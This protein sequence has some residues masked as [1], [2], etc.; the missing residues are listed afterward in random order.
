M[1]PSPALR[2]S[3][4]REVRM[5]NHHKRGRSL[6]GGLLFKDKDDDLALF[7]DMQNRERDNFLLQ[8]ADDLDDSLSTKLRYFSDFKLGISIPARG[9]SSDL[10]N[11]DGDKNDYDWL[12][13][14]PGTP[15]FPSLDDDP[16]PS[17]LVHRGRP[18]S[19][20]ISISR[21][22]K[23]EKSYRTSRSSASP[24]RLSPSPRSGNSTFQNSRSSASPHRLSPSAQSSSSA[25]SSRGRP[26]SARQS[27][28]TPTLRSATPSR[29]PS[30]PPNKPSSP[31]PR[32]ATPTM[33]RMSTGSSSLPSSSGRRAPSPG[34]AKRGNSASPK[35]QAWQSTLPGFSSDAP[36]N[37]RTS[38]SDRA[39]SHVRGLSPASSRSG[40][41][42][43][44]KFGRQSMS[45]TASRSASS[46]H[47]HERDRLSS[48]SK[49]SLASSVDDDMDSPQSVVVGLSESPSSRKNGAFASSKALAFSKKPSTKPLSASSAPKRSFDSA[50]RQMDH[51][52]SPQNMFRPLLSSVPS[53]T[54]YVGKAN[55]GHR[56]MISRNSSVTTS[57]NTSS[58]QGASI[59]HDTE[60]SDHDQ[61]ALASEWGKPSNSSVQE[62]IFVFDKVDE[63]SEDIGHEVSD[64]KPTKSDGSFGESATRQVEPRDSESNLVA[65]ENAATVESSYVML[66][67]K[68][69]DCC[70]MMAS[71]SICGSNFHI[72]GLTDENANVCPDCA[73]RGR[74]LTP[75]STVF[76]TQNILHADTALGEDKQCDDLQLEMGMHELQQVEKNG[77]Q[78]MHGQQGRDVKQGDGCLSDSCLVQLTEKEGEQHLLD[79]QVVG[80][81]EISSNQSNTVSERRLQHF[82]SFPSL[83]A[84]GSEATGISLLLKRTSSSKWPVV[85]GRAFTATNVVFDDPSYTRENVNAMRNLIGQGSASAS[86][87]VDLNSIKQIEVRVQRQLSSRKADMEN[88]REGS[89]SNLLSTTS[90]VSGMSNNASEALGHLK[91]TSEE[92]YLSVRNMEYEALQEA[93]VVTEGQL[94]DSEN[95]EAANKRH[96]FISTGVH[97]EFNLERMD[98]CR[99]LYTSASELSS[100]IGTMQLDD[101][102]AAEF[103]TI[104]GSI[105]HGNAEV[106]SNNARETEMEVSL[107]TG[108]SSVHGIE[109]SDP[110]VLESS[111]MEVEET[112]DGYDSST[113]QQMDCM[114]SPNSK[115]K[116][117]TFEEP[118]VTTS[119]EK[120]SL[121]T[122]PEINLSEHD[123]STI[124]VGGPSGQ[125]LR[126]L[127]L[128]EATD[129]ILFCS[130]IIHDLAYKAATIAM[131]KE[132]QVPLEGSRPTVT[133]F[134]KADSNK[135][136]LRSRTSRRTLKS[137]K[138]RQ[139]QS[140]ADAKSPSTNDENVAKMDSSLT[141]CD[142]AVP[143]KVDSMKPPKLESKCNCTVM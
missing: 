143:N 74:Q 96:S 56:S 66:D 39:A 10:L 54:F 69:A 36:P 133:I 40:R 89:N 83:K 121:G 84:D 141:A 33:R 103:L 123:E 114:E 129:T 63:V 98:G 77:T 93:P 109:A 112:E 4:A 14:P 97:E 7:K 118:L 90:S 23:V 101:S 2:V 106:L 91:S 55:S 9:E 126:S 12:L 110:P 142:S 43:S 58:E 99:A 100:H 85:Q 25:F 38:L 42:S 32:S 127:T 28:P 49:G 135:R 70:E 139:R 46:S 50:L 8:P 35:L 3:P 76:Y 128:D 27:S 65:A 111:N 130:S 57:S 134:G 73:E 132:D 44:S 71:C 60:G 15:L 136:D 95:A 88:S 80:Q 16:P 45:P 120:D 119:L 47:S 30:T 21:S 18:R 64:E 131:E 102:S 59:A 78:L 79:P 22:A 61:D 51:R 108:G 72:V 5:E 122:T 117:E 34:K 87:S 52:K 13:T 62:E 113:V 75:V 31:A 11:A 24:N 86:S 115:G 1:P 37:L 26:S 17:N 19:Q 41:D 29:R 67:P 92:T 116:I 125:R 53:T 94:R 124:T 107:A 68:E 6:E 138:G 104:E 82:N 81:Q 140:E 105:S 20:P 48:Q 137:Q